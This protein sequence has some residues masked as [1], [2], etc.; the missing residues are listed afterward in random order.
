MLPLTPVQIALIFHHLGLALGVGGAFVSDALFFSAI[1]NRV[2]TQQ[3]LLTLRLVSKLVVTGLAVLL[4]SGTFL[5][6]QNTPYYLTNPRFLAKMTIVAIITGNGLLFHALHLPRLA[7]I[8]DQPLSRLTRIPHAREFIL[9]S[10][11]FSSISWTSALILGLLINY[12]IF[13]YLQIIGLY[14]LAVTGASVTILLLRNK[15]IPAR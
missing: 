2:I 6:L 7:K 5:F 11:A 4:L 1:S 3:E 12:P 8:A 9:V 15:L 13:T 10:G 14:A